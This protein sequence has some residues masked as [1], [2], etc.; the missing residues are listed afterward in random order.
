MAASDAAMLGIAEVDMQTSFLA[1]LEEICKLENEAKAAVEQA[2][3]WRGKVRSAV[4]NQHKEHGADMAE[5]QACWKKRSEL[6]QQEENR[7]KIAGLS[8]G[9]L[10]SNWDAALAEMPVE[11][12]VLAEKDG[13]VFM[14]CLT[15]AQ[16]DRDQQDAPELRLNHVAPSASLGAKLAEVVAPANPNPKDDKTKDDKP[17]A[18]AEGTPREIPTKRNVGPEA[19]PKPCVS[20]PG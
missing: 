19:T 5:V 11:E 3:E 13:S 1:F 8:K 16:E 7:D 9:V 14:H 10:V 4:T 6:A 15:K 20:K 2:Q 12:N 18:E 17:D